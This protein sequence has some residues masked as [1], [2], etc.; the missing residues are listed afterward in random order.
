MLTLVKFLGIR[1]DLEHNLYDISASDSDPSDSIMLNTA[2]L[3]TGAT[4]TP[5]LPLTGNPVSST[6]SWKPTAN[7]VGTTIITFTAT[8]QLGLQALCPV[9]VE[10]VEIQPGIVEGGASIGALA[11]GQTNIKPNLSGKINSLYLNFSSDTEYRVLLPRTEI[12]RT[13]EPNQGTF[14][15]VIQNNWNAWY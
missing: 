6:F 9:T 14:D 10:V 1:K 8:D 5:T 12:L 3:P 15:I 4:M 13:A 11:P 2:E 7:D